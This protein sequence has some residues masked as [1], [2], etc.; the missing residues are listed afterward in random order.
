MNNNLMMS[1]MAGSTLPNYAR[2]SSE[3]E[4]KPFFGTALKSMAQDAQDQ[5]PNEK[6]ALQDQM[7]DFDIISS[8]DEMDKRL[9]DPDIKITKTDSLIVMSF[10]LPI[11]VIR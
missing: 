7:A 4:N 5:S 2:L 10:R 9:M 11:N 3:Y 8:A 6:Q 1:S